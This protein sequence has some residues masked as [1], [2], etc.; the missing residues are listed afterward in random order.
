MEVK[1]HMSLFQSVGERGSSLRVKEQQK[2]LH[3]RCAYNV[4]TYTMYMHIMYV[5]IHVHV[6]KAKQG[7]VNGSTQGRQLISKKKAELP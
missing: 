6:N 1:V 7:K 2:T 3:H 5:H 4:W